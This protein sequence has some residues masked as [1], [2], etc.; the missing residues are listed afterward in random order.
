MGSGCFA[1]S[2]FVA[3]AWD[4]CCMVSLGA[5]LLHPVA[6]PSDKASSTVID[7]RTSLPDTEVEVEVEVMRGR[8]FV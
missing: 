2:E 3:T 1:G 5:I 6:E 8:P 7:T 4:S